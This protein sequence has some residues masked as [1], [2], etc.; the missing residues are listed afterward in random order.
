MRAVGCACYHVCVQVVCVL[1]HR[2]TNNGE[3]PKNAM[4]LRSAP[5]MGSN[6]ILKYRGSPHIVKYRELSMFFCARMFTLP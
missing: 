3:N 6:H 1:L 2:S 5:D 4:L